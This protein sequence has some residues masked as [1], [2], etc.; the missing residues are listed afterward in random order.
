LNLVQNENC[1]GRSLLGHVKTEDTLG[2]F[3]LANRISLSGLYDTR[4]SL[5]ISRWQS[6]LQFEQLPI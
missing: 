6:K 3:F 5:T 2:N 4:K 1:N